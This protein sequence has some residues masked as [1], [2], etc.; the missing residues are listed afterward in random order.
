MDRPDPRVDCGVLEIAAEL[1]HTWVHPLLGPNPKKEFIMRHGR[2]SQILVAVA[3][4]GAQ[5]DAQVEAAFRHDLLDSV[6]TRRVDEA[7]GVDYAG[8]ALQRDGLDRYVTALASCSP[9]N[10]PDRFPTR[11]DRLAYWINAYNAFVLRGVLDA[12][13]IV[14]VADVEGGLDGFFRQ[15]RFVA[16]GDSLSL[17]DIENRIIR[18]TF[19]DPRIHFAVN[20]GAASCPAL[21]RRAYRAADLEAHLERQAHRFAADPVHVGWEEGHLR[22][23][24]IMDWYGE[25]FVKWFPAHARPT[26]DRAPTLI[27]YVR[28]Y[29]PAALVQHLSTGAEVAI[30]FDEYDWALNA[31]TPTPP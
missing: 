2:F 9:R 25:D 12:L 6:L 4:S 21:D 15:Q 19:R 26:R 28:L 22:L 11:G 3:L 27:D 20:C 29:A 23:S 30:V 18:P 17:D 14:S 13:P 31:T 5:V 1:T 8:L 7:G 16:G 10:C 24:R